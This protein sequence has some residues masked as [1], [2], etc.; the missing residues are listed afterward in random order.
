MASILSVLASSQAAQ[1]VGSQGNADKAAQPVGSQSNATALV[2]EGEGRGELFMFDGNCFIFY[3]RSYSC[4][5]CII[6]S[7]VYSS[8]TMVVLCCVVETLLHGGWSR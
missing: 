7:E 8:H 2:C 5:V 4:L 6:Y 1:P 3:E